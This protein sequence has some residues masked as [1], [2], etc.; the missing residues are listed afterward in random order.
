M[1]RFGKGEQWDQVNSMQRILSKGVR[2]QL[3]VD[4]CVEKTG[5]KTSTDV[6]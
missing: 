3:V 2:A 4:E 5:R 1:T 6:I